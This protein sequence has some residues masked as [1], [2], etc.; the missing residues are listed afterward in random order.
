MTTNTV[1]VVDYNE[2]ADVLAYMLSNKPELEEISG[3][4]LYDL[5]EQYVAQDSLSAVDT[6]LA[7]IYD[8]EFQDSPHDLL[9]KSAEF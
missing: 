5:W 3:S 1:T 2:S 4:K 6:A 7:K 9:N 8:D